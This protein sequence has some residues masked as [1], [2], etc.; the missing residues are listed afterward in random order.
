MKRFLMLALTGLALSAVPATAQIAVYG[1]GG[2][3]SPVGDDMDGIEAGLQLVGG[4]EY[5]LSD[6]LAILAEGQWGTHDVENSDNS[7]S[8]SALMGGLSLGLGSGEG[9]IKPWIFGAAGLQTVS[10][11]TDVADPSDTTFGYQVGAGIGFPLFGQNA[12]LR[13]SYQ[14]ASFDADSE[15]GGA[16]DFDFSIFSV[17][18]GFGI[19]LGG[20]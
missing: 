20:S 12:G 3:A 14:A 8:P 18:L 2:V 1:A 11:D 6:K 10:I 19:P 7:V 17:V 9:S 4:V 16:A 15:I 13:A 5:Y